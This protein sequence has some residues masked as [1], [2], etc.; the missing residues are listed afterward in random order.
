MSL[1]DLHV[2]ITGAS[3]G[4]GEALAQAA[5]M[6]GARV[7]LVARRYE[8]LQK[9][10]GQFPDGARS[11]LATVDLT[12]HEQCADWIAP[13]EAALGPIDLLINNAGMQIVDATAG[14]DPAAGE[15]LLRLN[16]FTPMRIALAVLPGMIAR[17]R[18]TIVNVASIAG[19]MPTPSMFYYNASKGGLGAASEG[20][21]GELRKT[22]VNVVTVYPGPVV[23]PMERAAREKLQ[24]S[25]VANRVPTGD[26]ATLTRLI[27]R[28]VERRRSRVIY[29]GFYRLI[30]HFPNLARFIT[31]RFMPSVTPPAK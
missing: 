25:G 14:S 28:A 30:R 12:L 18:G 8:L 5:A 26:V 21:R 31:E 16:V 23:T 24:M 29:P 6:E 15:T 10:A 27:Y 7:T 22:G 4:I 1:R 20:L 13:A 17:A 3:S 2:A 19:L 11:H 9:I